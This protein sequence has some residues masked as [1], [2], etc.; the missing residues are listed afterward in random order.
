MIRNVHI[1]GIL[2]VLTGVASLQGCS[3]GIPACEEPGDIC[4]YFGTNVAALAEEGACRT[5]APTY[6]VADM[7]VGPDGMVYVL[8]WNNHRVVTFDPPAEEGGCETLRVVTGTGM[9]GDGPAGPA[10]S[11]AWNHPTNIAFGDDGLMYVT[12]WHN[13]RVI[14]VDLSSGTCAFV[15]GTGKRSYNGEGLP[16]LE[17]DLDLPVGLEFGPDGLLY[18]ADQAN[19]MVRRINADG[20]ITDVVGTGIYGYSG[21]GGPAAD[22]QIFNELGQAATPGSRISFDLDAGL[23]YVADTGNHRVRVVDLATGVIN[24]FAGNGQMGSGGD[25]GDPLMA[26]LNAPRDVEVGPDGSLYIADSNNHCVRRVKDGMIT[27]VAGQCGT[28]GYEGNGGAATEA[29]LFTPLGIETDSAGNLYIAD[30]L[31]NEVRMVL[32]P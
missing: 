31:N 2:G 6:Q 11:A 26:S 27:S 17:T 30:T 16:A 22:A 3:S 5:E 14:S 12:A 21:D 7:T 8:D 13:S 10:E 19:Q 9:L 18:F 4:A 28:S 32:A 29:L 20:T 1:T 15:A 23:M 25:G 24:T